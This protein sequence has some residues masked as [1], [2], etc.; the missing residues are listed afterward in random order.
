MAPPHSFLYID[1]YNSMTDLASHLHLLDKNDGLY[2][3]YFRWKETGDVHLNY[4]PFQEEIVESITTPDKLF[5]SC[6]AVCGVS[7]KYLSVGKSRDS[8]GSDET[9]ENSTNVTFF[10]LMLTGGVVP[11]VNVE[12]ING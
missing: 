2:N 3:E 8:V 5:F 11:A 4:P 9:N 6:A 7:K 10:I 1:D 12:N